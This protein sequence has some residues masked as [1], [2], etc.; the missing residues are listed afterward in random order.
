[1]PLNGTFRSHIQDEMYLIDRASLPSKGVGTMVY[2]NMCAI[3]TLAVS[4]SPPFRSR[5]PPTK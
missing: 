5:L 4:S 2:Q 1:M 3:S